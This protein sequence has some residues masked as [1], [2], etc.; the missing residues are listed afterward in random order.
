MI[1]AFRYAGHRGVVNNYFRH[2]IGGESKMSASFSKAKQKIYAIFDRIDVIIL[3]IFVFRIV[4][5]YSYI[6]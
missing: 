3:Y 4:M 2:C 5:L 1:L 6:M